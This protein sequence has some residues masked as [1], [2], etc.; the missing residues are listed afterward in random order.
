LERAIIRHRS[1]DN[2]ERQK[3]AIIID[4]FAWLAVGPINVAGMCANGLTFSDNDQP[5]WIDTKANRAVRKAGRHTAPVA[6]ES[7]QHPLGTLLRNILQ[8]SGW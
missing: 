3:I 7:D 4:D 5:F 6:L 1:D 8:G 2:R